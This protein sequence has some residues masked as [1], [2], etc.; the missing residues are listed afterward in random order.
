MPVVVVV[1]RLAVKMA[2]WLLVGMNGG[3]TEEAK[4]SNWRNDFKIIVIVLLLFE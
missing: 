1:G 4:R 2:G 3:L